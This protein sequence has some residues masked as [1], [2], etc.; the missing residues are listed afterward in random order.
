MFLCRL[1]L[2]PRPLHYVIAYCQR[3]SSGASSAH[4]RHK[5]VSP[6]DTGV[7]CSL[8]KPTLVAPDAGRVKSTMTSGGC[9]G[10]KEKAPASICNNGV[11][12]E[13][14]TYEVVSEYYG[15]VLATSKDL[16]TG[17]CTAGGAPPLAIKKVTIQWSTVLF[18]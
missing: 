7:G 12:T 17:A 3:S 2:R 9:C 14:N 18:N 13:R 1:Q 6:I 16:K 11:A 8:V 4:I 5:H 10:S 15:R